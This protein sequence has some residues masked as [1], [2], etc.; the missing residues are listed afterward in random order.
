M[1]DSDQIVLDKGS[2]LRNE[3]KPEMHCIRYS[4]AIALIQ[5]QCN[6]NSLFAVS[7]LLNSDRPNYSKMHQLKV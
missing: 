3:I 5:V 2:W 4:P 7:Y 1:P 6:R